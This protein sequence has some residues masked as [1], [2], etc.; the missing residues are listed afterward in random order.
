VRARATAAFWAS[1]L[2]V[3]QARYWIRFGTVASAYV[4]AGKLGIGLSVAHGVITPVWAPSGIALAALLIFGRS[5]WPAVAVGA[6]VTNAT[7]GAEPLV[8]AGIACGNTLEAL[9]GR[10]LLEKVKFRMDLERVRDVLALVVLGAGVST[11][12]SATV[13][14]SVLAIAGFTGGSVRSDWVLW[15]FGDAMGNLLV[16]PLLLLAYVHRRWRPARAHLVEALL[17]LFSL[18]AISSIVFLA[19]AWRYP[20]FLFP[21]LLWAVLRFRQLG[22]AVSSFLVGLIATWGTV[23]G[24]ASIGATSETARVQ[25]IQALVAVLAIS[26]LVLGAILAERESARRAVEEG[27][28]RLSEAQALTHIGSWEWDLVTGRVTWSDELYRIFGLAPHE[29]AITTDF[30]LERVH[31]DDRA[32]L[33][34]TVRRAYVDRQPFALELRIVLGDGRA[35]PLEARG[36][37]VVGDQGEPVSIAGTAQDIADRRQAEALR[38]DVLSTVSHE[39]RTPLASV[40]N[41]GL[42]LRQRRGDLGG[43]EAARVVEQIVAEARRLD[44]ILSDMLEVDRIRHGRALPAREATDIKELVE[45]VASLHRAAERVIT[46]AAEPTSANVDTAKVERIVDNLIGNA[47][48]H[49]PAGTPIALRLERR[50]DDLLIVVDDGGPG[51]PDDHKASVF[52][53]F[54]R[55]EKVLSSGLGT[56]IGLSLVARFAALHGGRAWVED[57][58]AG[59]ASVRVLL[60]DCVLAPVPTKTP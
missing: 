48:K 30:L 53:I 50:G 29:R 34:D 16:T 20:Y 47:V 12:V 51:I 5:L 32:L 13:G 57:T 31:P 35:R 3:R 42:L 33:D 6:F 52:E 40:L 55:G 25:V 15:W 46:V 41:F 8:A 60:P 21:L 27:V 24:T 37:V 1:G 11:L 9:T 43:Q 45:Q 54:D 19:G 10:F 49:T 58:A 17:L 44:R 36:R 28:A 22:A 7:T 4:I 59:G 23:I 56:G 39:L 14:I 38:A 2:H 18:M 26:L